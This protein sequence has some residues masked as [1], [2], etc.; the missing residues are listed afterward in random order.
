ML[1]GYALLKINLTLV[2]CFLIYQLLL[3]K[4]TFYNLN[5]AFLLGALLL[6]VI[7]PLLNFELTNNATYVPAV[8]QHASQRLPQPAENSFDLA[9]LAALFFW[10]GVVILGFR[11]LSQ[12]ISLLLLYPGTTRSNIGGFPVRIMK[13]QGTS[14]F[15]FFGS[16]F[17]NPETLNGEDVHTVIQHEQVHVRQW[18]S[19][20]VL[21]GEVVRIFCWFNPAAWLLMTAIRENLEFIA[22][23]AVLRA[24]TER[25]AYQYSLIHISQSKQANPA[26]ANNFNFSHLKIRITMMNKTKSNDL[27]LVKYLVAVPLIAGLVFTFSISTGQQQKAPAVIKTRNEA[28]T[29]AA[30]PAKLVVRSKDG[31]ITADAIKVDPKTIKSIQIVSA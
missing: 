14:P 2:V 20:D 27:H 5:R 11:F 29:T 3:R 23:R 10:T 1:L 28:Q 22:D 4:L 30:K 7:T 19:L 12:L 17:L 26:I 25:K 6:S 24:G 21:W 8:L 16:I 9:G 15:S 13:R 18:H 31:T